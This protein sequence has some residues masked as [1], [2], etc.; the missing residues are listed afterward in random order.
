MFNKKINIDKSLYCKHF[1]KRKDKQEVEQFYVMVGTL[2]T[3]AAV[4]I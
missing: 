2:P 1:S 4:M 3:F